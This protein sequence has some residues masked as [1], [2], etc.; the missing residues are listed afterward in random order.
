MT[1]FQR[2]YSKKH[3]NGAFTYPRDWAGF[4]IPDFAIHKFMSVTFADW[5]N[6]YD[7]T[8]EEIYNKINKQHD[9]N[10]PYYVIGSEPKH[11]ETIDHELC[12]ALYYLIPA[13]KEHVNLIISKLNCVTFTNFKERL[14]KMGYSKP[15]ILDEINAYVCIDPFHLTDNIKMNK[16]EHKNFI[17]V[18]KDLKELF[19]SN[20][21]KLK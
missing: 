19:V 8:I 4:N 3:G 12:H 1:D 21:R 14:L 2:I 5:G 17:S 7:K 16:K 11:K 9:S 15:V 20:I 6:F 18:Q 10:M 13:Y